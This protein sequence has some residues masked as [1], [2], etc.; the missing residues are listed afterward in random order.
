MYKH[1]V[2][3]LVTRVYRH[4]W[5]KSIA[6]YEAALNPKG[7]GNSGKTACISDFVSKYITQANYYAVIP[8]AAILR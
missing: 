1:Y 3:L 7:R 2:S 5:F 4:V 6:V 8:A